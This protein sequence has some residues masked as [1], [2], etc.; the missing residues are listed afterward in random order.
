MMS[1]NTI[2]PTNRATIGR[3]DRE[4]VKSNVLDGIDLA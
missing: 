3:T 4:D 2:T 1:S